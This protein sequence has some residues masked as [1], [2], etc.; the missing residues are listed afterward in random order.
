[1]WTLRGQQNTRSREGRVSAK[2]LRCKR[3][4]CRNNSQWLTKFWEETDLEENWSNSRLSV[5]TF[6]RVTAPYACQLHALLIAGSKRRANNKYIVNQDN[7][8]LASGVSCDQKDSRL[9]EWYKKDLRNFKYEMCCRYRTIIWI[10]STNGR[11]ICYNSGKIS[12]PASL[13]PAK[14]VA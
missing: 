3:S 7:R 14:H 2:P 10:P 13:K 4:Q 5:C 11:G 1:M 12:R 6:M 8:A 9:N